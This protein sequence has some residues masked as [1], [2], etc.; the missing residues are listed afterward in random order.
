MQSLNTKAN[1][2]RPDNVYDLLIR[3]HDG[4]SKAQSDALNAR[5]VLILLN[6]IGDETILREAIALAQT[7]S[8]E[9]W[10]Q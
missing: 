5:L 8:S 9:K 6:H 4:L 7:T 10:P 1:I 3:A 2:A